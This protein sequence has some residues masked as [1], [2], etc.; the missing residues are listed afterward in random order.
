MFFCWLLYWLGHSITNGNPLC[1]QFLLFLQTIISS[2]GFIFYLQLVNRREA[3]EQKSIILQIKAAAVLCLIKV[4]MKYGRA[5]AWSS[6]RLW[7]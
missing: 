2:G 3:S 1:K 4:W 5:V 6:L 7:F